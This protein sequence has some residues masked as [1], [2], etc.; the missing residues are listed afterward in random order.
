MLFV[1]G[2]VCSD[3]AAVCFCSA[4]DTYSRL[5]QG[6]GPRAGGRIE[7]DIAQESALWLAPRA[8]ETP[9][10]GRLSATFRP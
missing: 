7:Q 5:G 1:T 8:V 2:G 6:E 4:P 9:W 3:S 10:E